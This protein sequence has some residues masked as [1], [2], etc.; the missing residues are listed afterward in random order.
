M[1]N[2]DFYGFRVEQTNV[3]EARGV[4]MAIETYE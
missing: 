1:E 2:E 4:L 3:M